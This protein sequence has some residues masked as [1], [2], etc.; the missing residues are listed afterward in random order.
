MK[1]TLRQLGKGVLFVLGCE[2]A[3]VLGS[4]FSFSAIPTWYVTLVKPPLNP[5]TWIFGPVWTTLYALMGTGAFLIWQQRSQKKEVKIALTLFISQL[6]VNTAWSI[7]FFGARS[8]GYAL[9]DILLLWVLILCTIISFYRI[10]KRAAWLLFPY[11]LWVSF[12]LYL[13][14]SIFLLNS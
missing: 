11:I 13:N 4:A 8:P 2:L 5:P 9:V 7:I 1:I 12:A 10:S 6:I 3:G 14:L